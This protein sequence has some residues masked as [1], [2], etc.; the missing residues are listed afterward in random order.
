MTDRKLANTI[1]AKYAA[2]CPNAPDYREYIEYVYDMTRAELE[3][4]NTLIS[5]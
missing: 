5:D 3:F 1:L 4:E 2:K